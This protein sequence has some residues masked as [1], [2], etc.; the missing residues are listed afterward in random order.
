MKII[1][2]Q[3]I[4]N[5]LL[6]YDVQTCKVKINSLLGMC[7]Q[8]FPNSTICV[9]EALPR[10]LDTKAQTATFRFKVT[11]INGELAGLNVKIIKQ[12]S[13]YNMNSTLYDKDGIHLTKTGMAGLV[14]NYKTALNP[15]LGLPDY[16]TYTHVGNT[17]IAPRFQ[18]PLNTQAPLNEPRK[19]NHLKGT[20][21]AV[22]RQIPK[23]K[24]KAHS[25]I[26]DVLGLFRCI[27]E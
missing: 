12:E 13:L 19:N 8:K 14:K 18:R 9:S 27:T 26:M 3:V 7:K 17:G 6:N 21:K 22:G 5:N 23:D 11:S 15:I 25:F 24:S 4:P 1:V 2:L 20:K 10:Q 16:S